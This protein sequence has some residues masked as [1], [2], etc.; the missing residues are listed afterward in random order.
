MFPLRARATRARRMPQP[1]RASK[2][3]PPGAGAS[4]TAA[5]TGRA[6]AAYKV[7]RTLP[8]PVE[9]PSTAPHRP[10]YP[11]YVRLKYPN[12]SSVQSGF[13]R[14]RAGLHLPTTGARCSTKT[15]WIQIWSRKGQI[16]SKRC[17]S[18]LTRPAELFGFRHAHH[19]QW[20]ATNRPPWALRSR[21]PG[22]KHD[23]TMTQRRSR[24]HNPKR[25]N[26]PRERRHSM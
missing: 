4:Q 12:T 15:P 14:N 20:H 21:L 13:E 22:T 5:S 17:G 2:D 6:A 7:R 1:F 3:S 18:T 24:N 8:V 19:I 26:M 16:W 25:K 9:R 10:L 23:R 11:L